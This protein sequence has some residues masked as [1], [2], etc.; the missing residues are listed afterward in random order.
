[1]NKAEFK[2]VKS[3]VRS[4]VF[5]LTYRGTLVF[6]NSYRECVKFR[7]LCLDGTIILD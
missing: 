7:N 4:S 3:G 6:C 1:M 5:Y 2:I